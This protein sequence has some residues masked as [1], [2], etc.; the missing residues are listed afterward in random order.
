MITAYKII[1]EIGI[2][3]ESI[4]DACVRAEA[5]SKEIERPNKIIAVK[6]DEEE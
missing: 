4:T 3:A 1:M 2:N 5:V 6:L